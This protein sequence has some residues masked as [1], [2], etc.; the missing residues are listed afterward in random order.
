MTRTT[1]PRFGIALLLS[2][3]HGDDDI[4][5][6]RDAQ[7]RDTEPQQHS[8]HSGSYP[9]DLVEQV[10][11]ATEFLSPCPFPPGYQ[12]FLGCVSGP[13]EGAM[14]VHFVNFALVDGKPE[15]KAPEAL[16]YDQGRRS[17]PPGGGRSNCA[18]G[19]LESCGR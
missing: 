9:F 2:C 13:E 1:F 16:I 18:G 17:G 14:G 19:R 7:A 12:Q 6:P 11:E 4:R 5:C 15:V 8:T 3:D 10:R